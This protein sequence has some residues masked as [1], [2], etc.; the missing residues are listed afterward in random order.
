MQ[1]HKN[2]AAAVKKYRV[3]DA[4]A[5][6]KPGQVETNLK[7][8][9]LDNPPF[10]PLLSSE[11]SNIYV[12]GDEEQNR[13]SLANILN[14]KPHDPFYK[15]YMKKGG[16][17]GPGDRN[18]Q[19]DPNFYSPPGIFDVV[20]DDDIASPNRREITSNTFPK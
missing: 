18:P 3:A 4:S 10:S 16:S 20:S 11:I 14:P 1:E 5:T 6:R 12:Y 8:N 17:T 19:N 13:S 2:S 15:A 9:T 7:N